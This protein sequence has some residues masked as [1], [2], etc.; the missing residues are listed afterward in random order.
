MAAP[1]IY[2]VGERYGR[3][4]VC[5]RRVP[6]DLYVDCICECG[7]LKSVRMF[8]LGRKTWSCGCLQAETRIAVNVTHGHAR[9]RSQGGFTPTYVVWAAMRARCTNPSNPNYADYGGRGIAVCARWANYEDFLSDMGERPSGL[10]IERIDNDAGYCLE[11]CRWATREEQSRNR[12]PRK[13]QSHCG[14]G[15]KY[16]PGRDERGRQ[17]CAECKAARDARYRQGVRAR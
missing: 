12:R 17:R 3:L 1:R 15:H 2:E 11:N 14:A 16:L 4:T 13:L 5:R 8:D 7:T 6:P 10:T 9:G